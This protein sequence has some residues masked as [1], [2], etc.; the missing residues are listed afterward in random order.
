MM[1]VFSFAQNNEDT[2]KYLFMGDSMSYNF[3]NDRHSYTKELGKNDHYPAI[4]ALTLGYEG[5]NL[6]GVTPFTRGGVRTTD[7]YACLCE[8]FDGDG[9]TLDMQSLIDTEHTCAHER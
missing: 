4:I 1:P 3:V 8:D 5:M 2:K 6:L 9:Y 7:I